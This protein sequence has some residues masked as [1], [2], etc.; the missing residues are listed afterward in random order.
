MFWGVFWFVCG[1]IVQ[2]FG[3]LFLLLH[4]GYCF[5]K[6]LVGLYLPA[7]EEGSRLV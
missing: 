2:E 1:G 4:C 7:K 6:E 3:D 5:W